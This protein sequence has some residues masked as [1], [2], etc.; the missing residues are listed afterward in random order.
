MSKFI[1]MPI[2]ITSA[3][4]VSAPQT[5]LTNP[6]IR[7][8]LTIQS[9]KNWIL[10]SSANKFVICDGSGFDLT[11]HLKLIKL[12]NSSI[13]FEIIFFTNDISEVIK[14]GKGYGEGEIINYALKHSHILKNSTEFAKCTGKLWVE[15]FDSCV[16]EFN[17]TYSF[18][19]KGLLRPIQIDTR[20]YLV[21]K[22]FYI[23]NLL[24]IHQLVDDKNGVYLEHSFKERLS[25]IK[26]ADYVMY[27][28]PRINGTSGSMGILYKKNKIKNYLRDIRSLLIKL[29]KFF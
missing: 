7:L 23:E 2:L 22:N 14:K 27:P 16:K 8:D 29:T 18:D 10:T 25:T 21:N 5:L 6:N 19:F 17:G 28:T 15:N 13:D 11:P 12:E 4:N 9:I 3:I 24:D 1:N 20:F 26:L